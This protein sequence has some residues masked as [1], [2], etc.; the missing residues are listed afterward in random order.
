MC[1][2]SSSTGRSPASPSSVVSRSPWSASTSRVSPVGVALGVEHR[3]LDRRD[4]A[5]EA[6]LVDGRARVRPGS[7]GRTRR[8]R[9]GSGRGRARSGRRPRTG[10]AGRCPSR[11][12]RRAGAGRDV[13]AA[14]APGDIISTPQA[15]P[16]SMA[17]AAIRPATRWVACWAEPHWASM[18]VP[19]V[20]WGRP[21][22]SQARRTSALRLLA[23]LRDAAADDLLDRVGVDA[24]AVDQRA[25][26][27]AEELCRRAGRPGSPR[28]CRS[29]CARPRR[30]RVSHGDLSLG[31]PQSRTCSHSRQ[32]TGAGYAAESSLRSDL[33]HGD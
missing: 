33:C 6:A 11:G 22:C 32:A 13:G 24:G 16:V 12:P 17:P 27:R 14:A 5:L 20:C 8:G 10:W 29:A 31:R 23:G 19:A 1:R 9:R 26:G 21:A 18:V 4:L 3:R 2:P 25:V 30:S 7:A 28:A 15:M